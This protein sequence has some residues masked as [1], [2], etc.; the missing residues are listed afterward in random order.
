[1][2][3]AT[4]HE[5]MLTRGYAVRPFANPAPLADVV[6]VCRDVLK[7]HGF[8]G[9]LTE[10]HTWAKD[11]EAHLRL[12]RTLTDAILTSTVLERLLRPEEAFLVSLLGPDVLIQAAPHLRVGRAGEETDGIGLHR[13]SFYGS[14][15]YHLNLWFPLAPL[16]AGSGLYLADGTHREPSRGVRDRVF[17]DAFRS[18]VKRGSLAHGLGFVYQP[19]IDDTIAALTPESLTLVA[20]EIGSYVLFFGCM[21]HA[22]SNSGD[23]TRWTLDVRFSKTNDGSAVRPGYFREFTRGVVTRVAQAFAPAA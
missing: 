23:T 20:P 21:V 5:E 16:P 22:G 4:A 19:R 3:F 8:T 18:S 14:S 10:Y 17:D 15:A 7:G 11:R 6:G 9:E 1:L 2:V 12:T 13:D